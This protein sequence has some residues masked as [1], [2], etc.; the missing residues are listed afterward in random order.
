MHSGVQLQAATNT[1]TSPKLSIVYRV[2]FEIKTTD[3]QTF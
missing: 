1:R 3:I 2:V